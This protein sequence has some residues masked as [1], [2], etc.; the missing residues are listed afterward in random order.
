M[1]KIL[2]FKAVRPSLDKVSLV[3]CR[4]YDDYTPS[5]LANCLNFNPYSF[6]HVISPAFSNIQKIDINKRFNSVFLK[7]KEF[8]HENILL[9]EENPVFYI[10]EIE[11]KE[12]TFTG[13]IAATSIDDLKNGIIK[14]HEDTISYRVELFKE[15]L[16]QTHFNTE[17]VLITYPDNYEINNWIILKKKTNSL[18]HFSTTDK[19]KH[20]LWKVDTISEIDWLISIFDKIPSL[21]IAD[22]HHRSASA[23]L[24][25]EEN[26]DKNNESLSSFM[27]FL[28]PES[29]IRIYEFNR[30]IKDLNGNSIEN[31][32]ELLE[33]NFTII[34]K[35]QEIW[36]PENKNEFGMY[37]DGNF[38]KLVYKKIKNTDLLGNLDA[39][40]LYD[41]VLKPILGIND[42][43]NDDRIEYISGKHSFLK[44]KQMIDDSMFK[45]GFILF[46]TNI[47]E[48]IKIAD[49]NLIM[50]PKSTYIEPKFKSGL[51][52]YEL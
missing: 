44:L 41:F 47:E 49:N 24:L 22:G 8:I 28:I 29:N 35:K 32:L 12:N 19:E 20:T 52:V 6:L 7:Y 17:P 39:Q 9:R 36:K 15:Y 30:L 46:P 51:V 11:N 5:E 16:Q 31:F 40:I 48:I 13:I 14:K 50:P 45:V 4:N 34:N 10:Y 21:Y 2:P 42:L 25:F 43:R 33:E 23:K 27:S 37:L 3:T 18:Y 1:S 26:K 38:Y